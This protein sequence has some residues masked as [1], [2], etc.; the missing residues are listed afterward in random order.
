VIR[1]VRPESWVG[2]FIDTLPVD[3]KMIKKVIDQ[4]NWNKVEIL[5]HIRSIECPVL[6]IE[7]SYTDPDRGTEGGSYDSPDSMELR[8]LTI[9]DFHNRGIGSYEKTKAMDQIILEETFDQIIRNNLEI[10]GG[11]Y[12]MSDG[13]GTANGIIWHP[14]L[15]CPGKVTFT[16]R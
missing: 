8:E 5:N 3:D 15:N 13:P 4:T 12:R 7:S 9:E 1:F 16:T 14:G 2:P 10:D 11:E 6:M